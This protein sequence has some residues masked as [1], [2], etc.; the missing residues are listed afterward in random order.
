MSTS[1]PGCKVRPIACAQ[2]VVE[3][4]HV[5]TEGDALGASAPRNAASVRARVAMRRSTSR[6]GQ[7]VAVRIDVAGAVEIAEP[8]DHRLRDL[9]AARSVEIRKLQSKRGARERRK[10]SAAA[11]R[12]IGS[13]WHSKVC[14]ENSAGDESVR[15]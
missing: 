4:G 15:L 8:V 13:K 2:R 12:V 7:K 10:I 6:E 9:A 5:L 3:R 11:K 14:H 1:S